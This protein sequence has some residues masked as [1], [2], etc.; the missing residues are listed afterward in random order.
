MSVHAEHGIER[1][2]GWAVARV[3]EHLVGAEH[4]PP[5]RPERAVVETREERRGAEQTLIGGVDEGRVHLHAHA[6]AR[7]GGQG[8][9]VHA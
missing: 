6:A 7:W 1:A 3:V 8:D 5:L 9:L 4:A 2:V